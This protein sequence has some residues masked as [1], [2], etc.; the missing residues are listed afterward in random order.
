MIAFA[1][2]TLQSGDATTFI[3]DQ[4]TAYHILLKGCQGKSSEPRVAFTQVFR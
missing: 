1:R 2:R 4:H 3:A